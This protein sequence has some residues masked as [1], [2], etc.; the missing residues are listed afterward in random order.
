MSEQIDKTA[1]AIEVFDT[2]AQLYMDKFMDLPDFYDS[3]DRFCK[4]IPQQNAQ[5]L[6]LACGPGN[7]THY[8]LQKRPD[9]RILGTDLA[10]NMLEL[11]K[12]NNPTAQFQLLDCRKS[13]SLGRKFDAVLCGF[14]LPYLSKTEAIQLI[15]DA[16]KIL[17]PEGVFYLSTMEDAY[18]K[19]DWKGAS[20]NPDYQAFIHYHE[21]PYLC[22]ALIENGF[23]I[24]H[25]D[26]IRSTDAKGEAVCDLVLI[27][28]KVKL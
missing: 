25:E 23:Q 17:K 21:A 3:F 13:L 14:G 7:I 15:Q 1:K 24:C 20:N 27:G 9:F 12:T 4:L 2:Y 26:R 6:E 28:R 16:A 11:A 19:S 22:A 8:L 5:I 18:E 10:P